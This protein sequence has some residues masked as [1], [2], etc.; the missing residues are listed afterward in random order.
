MQVQIFN[1]KI[2]IVII[3]MFS[4]SFISCRKIIQCNPVT[5]TD[6]FTIYDVKDGLIAYYNFNGG[7]LNDSSGFG[8]NI[9]ENYATP[10]S[11]RFGRANNAYLF[12]GTSSFMRVPNSITLTPFN[13]TIS[14]IF[15]IDGFYSGNCHGNDI[16]GKGY[17]DGLPGN[18]LMRFSDFNIPC[19]GTPDTNNITILG[20]SDGVGINA[21]STKLHT[22]EWYHCVYTYDGI[23][24]RMYVNG[25]LK[26]EQYA[27]LSYAPNSQ[28]L[29]IGKHGNPQYPYYFNGVMDEIRIYNR[30]LSE[31]AINQL[32]NF[33]N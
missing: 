18:Y 17:P 6:T 28:D 8:N 1:Y 19:S 2:T 15:R 32:Y 13:I 4:A 25:K 26:K 22:G 31:N 3:L 12:N 11:D 30:A 23:K 33:N 20:A 24:S 16:L 27:S 5:L 9:V 14:A 10:T 7:N 21:D 29:L